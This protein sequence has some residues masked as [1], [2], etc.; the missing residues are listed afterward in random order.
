MTDGKKTDAEI[1]EAQARLQKYLYL[2]ALKPTGMETRSDVIPYLKESG[3]VHLLADVWLLRSHYPFADDIR[4]EIE[5][6]KEFQGQLFVVKLSKPADLAWWRLSEEAN[7]W[8]SE[9]LIQ[10]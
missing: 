9:N 2:V 6:W 5:R 3:A 8:I 10:T 4:H 1:A 7:S